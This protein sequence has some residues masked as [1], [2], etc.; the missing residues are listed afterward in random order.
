METIITTKN[1]AQKVNIN[2]RKAIRLKCLDCSGFSYVEVTNCAFKDCSLYPYRTGQGKQ[3][4][5]ARDK[6]IRAYCLE[7]MNGKRAEVTK[8]PSSDCSLFLFRKTG[9]RNTENIKSLTKNDAIRQISNT[10]MNIT[11]KDSLII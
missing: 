6:A 3:N 9:L 2:R 11:Y 1:G 4:P 7:C 8:C 5:K 10:Q